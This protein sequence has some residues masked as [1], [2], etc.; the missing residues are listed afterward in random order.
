MFLPIPVLQSVQSDVLCWG[1]HSIEQAIVVL[2]HAILEVP[3]LDF[4]LFNLR[5]V[6]AAP[7]R[8]LLLPLPHRLFI[9]LHFL[10]G[11]VAL[12]HLECPEGL[13]FPPAFLRR[14]FFVEVL[15]RQAGRLLRRQFD[16]A[17]QVPKLHIQFVL[18]LLHIIDLYLRLLDLFSVGLTL[19]PLLHARAHCLNGLTDITLHFLQGVE[20]GEKVPVLALEIRNLFL[21]FLHLPSEFFNVLPRFLRRLDDLAL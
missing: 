2:H 20:T 4:N 13:C 7:L 12:F 16:L 8:D 11:S 15:V 14:L 1:L 21:F 3:V 18:L 9:F 6:I 17:L 10:A 5:V 19:L